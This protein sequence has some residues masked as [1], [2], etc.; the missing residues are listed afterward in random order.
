[1][2]PRSK[3]AICNV[4]G[5]LI[6]ELQQQRSTLAHEL[7][8]LRSALEHRNAHEAEDLAQVNRRLSELERGRAH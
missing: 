1:M 4:L 8:E 3:E 7:A 5:H 6:D 2:G